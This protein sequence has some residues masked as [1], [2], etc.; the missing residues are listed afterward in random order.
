M[1]KLTHYQTDI[2][3]I[4]PIS[5]GK[6][7]VGAL[8]ANKLGL[9]QISMDDVRWDYYKE[10]GFE[11][12]KQKEITDQ[13][14]FR[15]LLDYWKPFEAHAVERLLQDHQGC[16]FDFGAGHSVYDDEALFAKVAA[17]LAPYQNV[18]LLLPSPDLD[19]SV[20]IVRERFLRDQELDGVFDG[21]DLH[22]YFVRHPS[23]QR[24]A[25]QV[26][27]TEGKS[28]E[29]TCDEILDLIGRAE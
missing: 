18:I 7:T 23:N 16:V 11:E 27:Y 29:M 14:G 5:T 6:S 24:L 10:I 20:E 19:K 8:L 25:K 26:V 17:V 21:F 9:P 15:G 13:H 3:L 2:I 1:S 28:V 12:E 22:E 4:G